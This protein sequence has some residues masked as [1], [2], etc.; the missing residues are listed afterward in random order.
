M[1]WGNDFG[2][3]LSRV[4]LTSIIVFEEDFLYNTGSTS[5][6]YEHVIISSFYLFLKSL[7]LFQE[8]GEQILS[9]PKVLQNAKI[10]SGLR[11]I[12]STIE[13]CGKSLETLPVISPD[14][15]ILF[16]RSFRALGREICSFAVILERLLGS[17][18][19]DE[20]I[21]LEGE[22]RDCAP[23]ISIRSVG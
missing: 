10:Q 14:K 2:L 8:L 13:T 5:G 19:Q 21:R 23:K 1:N 20:L 18:D 11:N 17:K 15:S 4:G 7:S 9:E 12:V 22:I 3:M 16:D 6:E